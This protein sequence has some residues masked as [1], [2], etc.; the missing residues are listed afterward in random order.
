MELG[1]IGL[2]RMGGNMARRL[3]ERG[4]GILAFDALPET[5]RQTEAFGAT[6]AASLA[7]LVLNLRP[8]RSVWTMIPA[9]EAT[10]QV[11]ARLR[12]LLDRGDTV[13]DGGN[14]NYKDSLRRAH[15]LQERGIRFMDV[16]VSGGIWGLAEGYSL[17]VGGDSDLVERHR[18]LFE[19]LALGPDRG[20]GHVGPVGAGHF[21]KMV[22]NAVEYGLME[23]YAEGF[24]LL[25]AKR[26]FGL[27][28]GQ[29]AQI[30][31]HGSVVRSWLLDLTADLL[32]D[33]PA[34][35]Q[36]RGYVPDTGEGR[37]AVA[38]AIDLNLCVPVITGA[39]ERR[40]RSREA[41]PLSDKIL[42]ALR[43]KFGGHAVQRRSDAT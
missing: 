43:E 16:G 25:A 19:T 32:A 38:E 14:S 9:G 15:D 31:R 39:L 26:D 30:W 34:L 28:L 20:W 27:D 42:A 8:P 3:L 2:G 29:V 22:H 41:E 21:V 35:R 23:A 13:I 5:V 1:M 33:E 40:L 17:M 12:G 4:H 11:I 24:E 37:W 6:G 18:G 36:V 10:E 7:D